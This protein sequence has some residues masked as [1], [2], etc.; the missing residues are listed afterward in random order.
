MS[1]PRKH[2]SLLQQHHRTY[3]Q[4]SNNVPSHV[5]SVDNAP[6]GQSSSSS[7]S[8]KSGALGILSHLVSEGTT[9]RRVFEFRHTFV[10]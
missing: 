6:T 10:G 1:L 3:L 5:G 9:F 7:S 4:Q 8:G 2:A